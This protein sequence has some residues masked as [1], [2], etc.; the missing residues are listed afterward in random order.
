M[1]GE[2]AIKWQ[3]IIS[4]KSW[5]H[6]LGSG[7]MSGLGVA[8]SSKISPVFGP[9]GPNG[10]FFLVDASHLP[11]QP[12]LLVVVWKSRKNTVSRNFILEVGR[13]YI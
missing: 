2:K 8:L 1:P 13:G 7:A 5:R 12:C 10:L 9:C 3:G 6:G 11:P 4:L